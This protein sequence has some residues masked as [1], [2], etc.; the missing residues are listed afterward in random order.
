MVHQVVLRQDE[1][2]LREMERTPR[3]GNANHGRLTYVEPN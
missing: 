3:S 1:C 2:P